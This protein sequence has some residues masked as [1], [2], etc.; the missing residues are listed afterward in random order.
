SQ[1]DLEKQHAASV[2]RACAS[3][4]AAAS[5]QGG[6]PAPGLADFRQACVD[7]LVWILTRFEEREQVFHD[8]L[9]ARLPSDDPQRR[10]AEGALATAGS[11]REA[12]AKLE[13]ALGSDGTARWN[14]FLQF[15]TQAWSQRRDELDRLFAQHAKTTDWRTVSA[16]D[17]DSIFDERHRYAR[18]QAALPV[19]VELNATVRA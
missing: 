17:A 5:T 12:L 13:T 9:R 7:Y 8:L 3:A 14:D 16:I 6:S 10:A 11:S 4:L 19:G 1:L 2:S 18:V 15:F